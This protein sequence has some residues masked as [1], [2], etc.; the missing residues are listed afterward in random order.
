MRRLLRRLAWLVA[1]LLLVLML[2]FCLL[3][4]ATRRTP[5]PLDYA[6]DR[7]ERSGLPLLW[8]VHPH[9]LQSRVRDL[10]LRFS[11]GPSSEALNELT[12]LGGATFPL[13]VPQLPNLDVV[14]AKKVASSLLPVAQRMNWRGAKDVENEEGAR[15][16]LID[17][18]K[19]HEVD[20]QPSIAAR[21]VERLAARGSDAMSL[22]IAE[23]D[24]YALPALIAALDSHPSPQNAPRTRRL[25][26]ALNRLTKLG[27]PA[28]D[29]A[30]SEDL[31]RAVEGWQR[32][33]QLHATEYTVTRGPA[34]WSAMLTQTQFGQ[35][36]NLALRF[37]FGTDRN[38]EP[39]LEALVLPAA[40]S[41][42]LLLAACLGAS[43]AV[44]ARIPSSRAAWLAI[45]RRHLTAIPHISLLAVLGLLPLR[46]SLAAAACTALLL[47]AC[48][49]PFRT[50]EPWTDAIHLDARP[51]ALDRLSLLWQF[52]GHSW[53]FL[54]TFVFV[55]EKAFDIRGLGLACIDGFR[56]RD[57]HQLMG[58]ATMTAA[59]LLIVELMVRWSTGRH[60][61][62]SSEVQHE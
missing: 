56:F 1:R 53:P 6:S 28:P 33:W 40:C 8:N 35:W 4:A 36:L 48:T 27:Y 20:F 5:A 25:L 18:W 41:G 62:A 34:R 23:Y 22:A 51:S 14:T 17:S 59:C 2:S 45:G 55:V 29:R 13:I 10:V 57:L 12:R 3:A 9:D 26:T 49:A 15:K 19:E 37:R 58:T 24:T 38:H 50:I 39:V 54:L 21:W 43:S 7:I 31:S 60:S 44:L 11:Q 42:L 52:A 32:W 16:F 46:G 47:A 61:A 30:S